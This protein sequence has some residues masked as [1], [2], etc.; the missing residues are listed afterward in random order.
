MIGVL[1]VC[2]KDTE[3]VG[4]SVRHTV[5]QFSYLSVRQDNLMK[6]GTRKT[7]HIVRNLKLCMGN[8]K[9]HLAYNGRPSDRG[10]GT[11]HMSML[12]TNYQLDL[13]KSLIITVYYYDYYYCGECG[14]VACYQQQP[15]HSNHNHHAPKKPSY[16][17]VLGTVL[18]T[19]R[20]R[21]TDKDNNSTQ[22]ST[23]IF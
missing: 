14:D 22:L 11:S 19:H 17:I 8:T 5:S 7:K 16:L 9:I 13:N 20:K 12:T 6:H 21:H 2:A 15:L 1:C 4:H 10:H 23:D 18:C 3:K